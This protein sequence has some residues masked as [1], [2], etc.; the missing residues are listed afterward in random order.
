MKCRHCDSEVSLQ[1]IDLGYA[2]P[3]N[4]YLTEADLNKPEMYL[5]LRV[6][7]CEECWLVQ[8]ED[9]VQRHTLFTS[10]YAYFSSTSTSWVKHAKDYFEMITAELSLG[11]DS[12][13]VELASND[14]YLLRNFVELEIPCL[15]IEPTEETAFRAESSGVQTIQDFFG[16]DL[17]TKL[18]ANYPKADLIVG[19]NVYAHVPDINDFTSGIKL[20]LAPAGTV[21]LEFP[22]LLNLIAEC[23]F[24]TIYH[25]HYSYLSLR[26]VMRIFES[27]GL[28]I[29][30]V[31]KLST[32]G[33]S[34][35]VFGCHEENPRRVEESV[36]RIISEEDTFGL[37]K[38]EKYTDFEKHAI[39]VRNEFTQ[40]LIAK[41]RLGHLV[42]AY[43]AAAKG[44]T[45]LNYAGIKKDLLPFVFDAAPSK[46]RKFLPG[47]HIPVRNPDNLRSLNPHTVLI[48]PWNLA[49]EITEE[50]GELVTSD[51]EFV[52]AIPRMTQLARSI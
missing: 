37:E 5:P 31:E 19:N 42:V 21:T 35:R 12:F 52:V 45:L 22:H 36:S 2:P 43:G 44:N 17:A 38:A 28:R 41:Q 15:G 7:V 26:V 23:Q 29:F 47:T 39:G 51:T 30:R 16:M 34:I 11:K 4:A 27:A 25:E 1:M 50:L 10:N 6:K 20:L 18:R 13:V 48:F 9:F 3:S 46:Q 33:G 32:H 24:D 14:G 49:P 40:F 8:T